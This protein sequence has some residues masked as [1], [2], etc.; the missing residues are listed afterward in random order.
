MRTLIELMTLGNPIVNTF[1]GQFENIP[2]PAMYC[3]AANK[4]HLFQ[5]QGAM[6]TETN[7]SS[8]CFIVA[9]DKQNPRHVSH[10]LAGDA[11]DKLEST[12]GK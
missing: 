8:L 9:W 12:L 4:S 10:Y 5:G 1:P 6:T 11:E 2:W 7:K 3:I